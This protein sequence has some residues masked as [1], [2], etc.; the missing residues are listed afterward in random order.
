MEVFEFGTEFYHYD[1]KCTVSCYCKFND[2]YYCKCDYK[3]GIGY[4][5]FSSIYV[6]QCIRGKK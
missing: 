2:R 4:E 5:W 6:R 1:L 3:D